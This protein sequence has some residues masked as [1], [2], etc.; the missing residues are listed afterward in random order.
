MTTLDLNETIFNTDLDNQQEVAP[1]ATPNNRNASRWQTIA[2]GGAT[3]IALGV[4][5][6]YLMKAWIAQ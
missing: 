5:G 2:I 3:G 4:A 6:T 1:E